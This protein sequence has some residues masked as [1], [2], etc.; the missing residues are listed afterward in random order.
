MEEMTCA[1]SSPDRLDKTIFR[2]DKMIGWENNDRGIS[3]PCSNKGQRKEHS[4]GVSTIMWLNNNMSRRISLRGFIEKLPMVPTDHRDCMFG[5][6]QSVGPIQ[7]M[8]EHGSFS[9]KRT[10]LF[11]LVTAQAFFD[12]GAGPF[13]VSTS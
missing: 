3:I 1:N 12:K 9:D 7:G 13:P 6:H 8:L 2:K 10:I 4:C 11:G 5:L